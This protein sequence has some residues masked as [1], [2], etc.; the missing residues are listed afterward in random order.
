MGFMPLSP[1]LGVV[2]PV[3]AAVED[4]EGEGRAEGG[5]RGGVALGATGAGGAAEGAEGAEEGAVI[6]G[7][8]TTVVGAEGEAEPVGSGL[9]GSA[10]ARIEITTAPTIAAPTSPSATT[11]GA[12]PR[13]RAG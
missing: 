4:V 5:G 11:I 6:V 2:A 13:A 12:L 1:G 8:T 10:G 3:L 7:A 9:A